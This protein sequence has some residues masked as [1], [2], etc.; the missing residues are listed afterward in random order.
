MPKL[1]M[2]L[3]WVHLRSL[4]CETPLETEELLLQVE[5][6]QHVKLWKVPERGASLQCLQCSHLTPLRIAAANQLA[7]IVLRILHKMSTNKHL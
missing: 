3:L 2:V 1:A 6:Q 7:V 4:V 5:F